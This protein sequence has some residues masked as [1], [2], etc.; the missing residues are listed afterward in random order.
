MANFAI[1]VVGIGNIAS[2][3]LDQ[4]A[5][6]LPAHVQL[7]SLH[8]SQRSLV[9]GQR[10]DCQTWRDAW[11]QAGARQAIEP[12]ITALRDQGQQVIVL[13]LTASKT[14]S[15][16]YPNWFAA[17]AD[18]VSANKY[19]GSSHP[20]FY[21]QLQCQLQ[22]SGQRW[23]YNTTVGAGLPIQ[24]TIRERLACH[25]QLRRLEG[26]FSG[27]LSWIFQHYQPGDRLSDWLQQAVQRGLTEPDPRIDLS[28]MDV[29]RKLLILAREA[30]W[31]LALADISVSNL[32]PEPLRTCSLEQFW[33]QR[34]LFDQSF[35]QWRRSQ[36]PQAQQFCY[37]GAVQ[38][39]SHGVVAAA[40]LT[41]ITRQSLY[42]HLPP[43][44]AN[45]IIYSQH[46]ADNP[47]IIQGPGAG[48]E[49][50]AAGVHSDILELIN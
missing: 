31:Q 1:I 40:E 9:L 4:F 36:H 6:K 27:S 5:D 14:V 43:G 48:R 24:R 45:F 15:R 25:D 19:G 47:L 39:H 38:R 22:Q 17:G 2:T 7:H 26:N 8:S 33:Q 30:G 41:P 10:Y 3:W 20:D 42:A 13:D 50:T 18:V 16:D 34:E 49:V 44:N 46:Y 35:E 29:A 21:D 11:Q 12:L 23:L 28:G 32:V 37:L